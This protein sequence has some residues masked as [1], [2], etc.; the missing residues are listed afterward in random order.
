MSFPPPPKETVQ[1]DRLSLAV[2]DEVNGHVEST[3]TAADEKWSEPKFVHDP[4]IRVHGLSPALNYGMQAYEGLKA[5]RASDGTIN[6]FRPTAHAARL[7]SSAACVSIPAIPESHFLK[8]VK[9]AV[10]RNSEWVGPNSSEALLYIRPLVFGSSG[11]LA[12][13]APA[14]FTFAVYVQP[15]TTYHGVQPLPACV[16]EDF[17]RAAP[18]GTGA[19][20]VG[21]NYPGVHTYRL[22]P[23]PAGI[24]SAKRGYQPKGVI[25]SAFFFNI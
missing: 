14:E 5:H 15:G 10:A 12:L 19:A 21:G 9:L 6:I 17:D 18:R 13:T 23:T 3:Y 24:G 22:P 20:K 8:C 4:Y 2:Q 7:S 25:T 1:W 16:I 11:H